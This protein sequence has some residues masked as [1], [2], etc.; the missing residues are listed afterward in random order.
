[1]WYILN[2]GSFIYFGKTKNIRKGMEIFET[3]KYMLE[4]LKILILENK[5]AKTI[6]S[7]IN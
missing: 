7:N 4:K 5:L 3:E 1:M 2:K 6:K